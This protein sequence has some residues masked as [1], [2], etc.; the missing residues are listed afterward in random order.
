MRNKKIKELFERELENT[1]HMNERAEYAKRN[2][3][4][5]KRNPNL[6]MFNKA[7]FLV[8]S[9]MIVLASIG[10]SGIA[11]YAINQHINEERIRDNLLQNNEIENEANEYL[12]VICPNHSKYPLVTRNFSTRYYLSIYDGHEFAPNGSMNILY[13]YQFGCYDNRSFNIKLNFYIEINNYQEKVLTQKIIAPLTI[14]QNKEL[15]SLY[16]DVYENNQLLTTLT[17]I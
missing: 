1:F 3:V 9:S 11:T 10:I 12:D 13:F 16:V 14:N 17:L 6:F 8:L 4:F 5:T 15:S 7:K 2:L